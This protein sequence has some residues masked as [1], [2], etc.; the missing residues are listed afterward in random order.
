MGD[1]EDYKEVGEKFISVMEGEFYPDY[2]K[3]AV[4]SYS[5]PI[6]HFQKLLDSRLTL[7]NSRE[8][9]KIFSRMKK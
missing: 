8:R 9:R 3:S 1:F 4:E 7:L 6:S 2:L 5:E